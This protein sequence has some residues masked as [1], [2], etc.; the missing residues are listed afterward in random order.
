LRAAATVGDV[1]ADDDSLYIDLIYTDGLPAEYNVRFSSRAQQQGFPEDF[2][3]PLIAQRNPLTLAAPIPHD[4]N[5]RQRYPRPDSYTMILDVLDTC[6]VWRDWTLTFMVRYPSWLIVQKWDDVL[7]LLNE[8]YNGGYVFSAIRW[9]HEG[10]AITSRGA[11]DSYIYE[12]PTLSFDE[13]YWVELTRADDGVTIP[14]CSVY[15]SLN[16][17]EHERPQSEEAERCRVYYIDGKLI[18]EDSISEIQESLS[19]IPA[20]IYI[21]I[22]Y[23]KAG[24]RI[25][26][27]KRVQRYE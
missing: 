22:Y 19:R 17:Q 26:T 4:P 5:D 25:E 1:C 27:Q 11:H 10:E 12:K 9:Y 13:A 15:P 20:G 3:K 7:A 14:S 2:G 6:G 24:E 23:N 16:R 18:A 8:D 21:L